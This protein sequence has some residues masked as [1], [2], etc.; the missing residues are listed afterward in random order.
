MSGCMLMS[1]LLYHQTTRFRGRSKSY[2][3]GGRCKMRPGRMIPNQGKSMKEQGSDT[4]SDQDLISLMICPLNELLPGLCLNYC[5][6]TSS[7]LVS[8]S[9]FIAS[10]P[11]TLVARPIFLVTTT[12]DLYVLHYIICKFTIGRFPTAYWTWSLF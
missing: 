7:L 8:P 6:Y 11:T 5:T 3:E 4:L 1:F 12:N 2:R 10:C 9:V